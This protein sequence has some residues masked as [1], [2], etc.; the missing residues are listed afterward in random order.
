[1]DRIIPVMIRNRIAT[2]PVEAEYICGNSDFVIEFD[3]DSEWCEVDTKTARFV[4]NETYQDVVFTGTECP[5]PIITDTHRFK[6]GVFAGNLRTTTPAR[7]VAKKS[8]LCSSGAPDPPS[9]DVYAQIMELLSAL[10]EDVSQ[11]E[12]EAALDKYFDE[13]PHL[14]G[15]LPPVTE[16]DNGKILTVVNGVWSVRE[17]MN[18][19]GVVVTF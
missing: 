11:E 8:I 4:Y 10:D 3:F 18:S 14:D 6:I 7:V 19:D 2:A 17:F 15:M 13:N 16:I 12:I 1:M 9:E 5:V